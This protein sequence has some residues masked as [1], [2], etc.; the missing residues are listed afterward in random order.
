MVGRGTSFDAGAKSVWQAARSAYVQAVES[1]PVEDDALRARRVEEMTPRITVDL[2]LAGEFTPLLAEDEATVALQVPPG[3]DGLAVRVGERIEGVFPGTMLSTSTSV[4]EA[5]RVA[6]SRLN[7]PPRPLRELRHA[8]PLTI[9]RFPVRQVAQAREG[10]PPEFLYRGG[11]VVAPTEV[12]GRRLRAAASA[13]ASHLISHAWP[14]EEPHGLTGDYDLLTDRYDPL[15]APP[16]EQ[17]AVALALA[18]F[19]AAPGIPPRD[20]DRARRFAAEVVE[21]LVAVAPEEADPFAEALPAAMWLAARQ[22]VLDAGGR[23]ATDADA[24]ARAHEAAAAAIRMEG[25]AVAWTDRAP[26]AGRGLIAFALAI[27]AR[28][29]GARREA[30]AVVR[31]VFRETGSGQLVSEMPWLAW[32]DMA[33]HA[34]P[35]DLPSAV[36][37]VEL[38][39]AAYS[40][41]L[42]EADLTAE[43]ADLLGAFV[44]SR[45]RSILP[46]WHA[47]RPSATVATM[48]GDP[49][50]TPDGEVVAEMSRLRPALRYLLQLVVEDPLLHLAR[51]RERAIGGVRPAVWEQA[52]ALEPA[53]MALLTLTETLRAMEA[54]SGAKAGGKP[55]ENAPEP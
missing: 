54:R 27:G 11:R 41:Q 16:V 7:L 3:I 4:S 25:D 10:S 37:L 13:I 22:A 5:L 49:R 2:Q 39:R 52:A 1:L 33:L 14:G 12:A 40:F 21:K 19:S 55:P 46:T 32:A 43:G 50:L 35:E 24:A 20:A 18:R 6:L 31:A 45:S 29:E 48:L 23:V 36:A 44:F 51:D 8:A 15:I 30:E 9:Y 42:G 34:S 38:R 28:D 17:A 26:T 47:L 53:A